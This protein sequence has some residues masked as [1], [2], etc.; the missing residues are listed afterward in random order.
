MTA[1]GISRRQ[2]LRTALAGAAAASPFFSWAQ[3]PDYF[4]WDVVVIGS[5]MAGL[6]AACA[7]H[8]AGAQNILVLEKGPLIGGHTLYS[9]GSIA[10]VSPKRQRPRGIE[11]S[12]ERFV[13]D[14]QLVSNHTGNDAI[15]RQ[16]AAESEAGVDWLESLGIA[17]SPIFLAQGGVSPRCVARPGNSAGRSYIMAL[18][19]EINR[20]RIPV[21][22]SSP[23]LGLWREFDLWR[24]DVGG[25]KD[26]VVRSRTV[27]LATG[28]FTA[29][30]PWRMRTNAAL[31]DTIRTSANPDGTVWDGAM[32]DGLTL[33]RN[34][35]ADITAG[36]G[37]QLL[38]YWGGRLLDYAGGDIY[39]THQGQRFVDENAPWRE[40]AASILQLPGHS[41]WVLTDAK[42]YKDA[43]LGLKLINGIVHKSDSLEDAAAGMHIDTSTLLRTVSRYNRFAAQGKDEDFGKTVF[44]QTIDTPPFYW[45]AET[46]YVHTSLDGIRT[47][48]Y[49]RVLDN[50]GTPLPELFAAGET[51]GGVFG[52]DRLGGGALTCALVMGRE[53]GKKAAAAVRSQSLL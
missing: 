15:L 30:V 32:G 8:Y 20:L 50:S 7:A 29:N 41:F 17:F 4:V 6:S 26:N 13:A 2:C 48:E 3:V 27:V 39:L 9:S 38:C 25:A 43:S 52:E 23:V 5:G 21:S 42:S 47:D 36:T 34:V 46:I 16:I 1:R 33:A 14:A 35:G 28:G 31:N 40:L 53:A 37:C 19:K 45:G 10:V 18:S 12:I 51:V 11:D 24:L 22:M 49:A 44:A